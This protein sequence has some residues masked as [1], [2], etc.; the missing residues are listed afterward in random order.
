MRVYLYVHYN[1]CESVKADGE[2]V[3]NLGQRL[4]GKG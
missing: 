2:I 4:G 1:G 3:R